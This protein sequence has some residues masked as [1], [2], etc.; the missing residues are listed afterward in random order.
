MPD[1]LTPTPAPTRPMWLVIWGALTLAPVVYTALAQ[2]IATPQGRP[3]TFDTMRLAFIGLAV[4][5][6]VAGSVL[7]AKAA[8]PGGPPAPAPPAGAASPTNAREIAAP[9]AFQTR[10]IIAMALFES[11]A[12]YGWVLF[13]L[14]APRAQILP[15]SAASI[16]GLV[17]IVL[18]SGLAYWRRWEMAA[19]GTKPIG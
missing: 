14:G 10:S 8:S 15:W 4:L 2:V 11:I 16:A 12:I 1:S 19:S 17:A 3:A 18:P 6:F 13:L 9:A 7:M 5:Q